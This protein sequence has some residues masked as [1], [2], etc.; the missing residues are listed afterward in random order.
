MEGNGKHE[1]EI[2]KGK[3]RDEKVGLV[4]FPEMQDCDAAFFHHEYPGQHHA[5]HE[6]NSQYCE[7]I[8]HGASTLQ[9][10]FARVAARRCVIRR[11]DP[12]KSSIDSIS[13]MCKF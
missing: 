8:L 1:V 11:D 9:Q 5:D 4:E 7:I 2:E 10:V 13:W 3:G 6:D 12:R